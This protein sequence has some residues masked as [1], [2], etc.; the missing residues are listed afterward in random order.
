M[1]VRAEWLVVGGSPEP[2]RRLGLTVVDGAVPL[3]GTGIR[4]DPDAE[5]GIVGWAL[6]GVPDAGPPAWRATDIDG[7]RTEHVA[8]GESR[9][10]RARQRCHRP[11]PRGRHHERAGA[12]VPGDRVGHRL[13]AAASS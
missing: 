4:F 11:R 7:L 2:W 9:P 3:F 12:H 13:A 6:S 1:T 8:A 5:P 10:R